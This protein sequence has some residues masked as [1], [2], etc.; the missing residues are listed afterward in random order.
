MAEVYYIDDNGVRHVAS[1]SR[2]ISSEAEAIK[3]H[4][5]EGV[6]MVKACFELMAEVSDTARAA[7]ARNPEL[8]WVCG[9]FMIQAEAMLHHALDRHTYGNQARSLGAASLNDWTTA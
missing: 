3:Q 8:Y 6:E 5:E 9:R 1:A 2:H 4:M 7:H